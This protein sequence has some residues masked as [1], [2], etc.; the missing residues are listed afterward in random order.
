[1]LYK[2]ILFLAVTLFSLI[3]NGQE[4]DITVVTEEAFPL[5]FSVE[6]EIVGPTTDLVQA[7]LQ[8]ADLSYD[9]AAMPWA[10]AYEQAKYKPNTLIYS[11]ARSEERESIFHWIG[12]VARFEYFFYT[13]KEFADKHTITKDTIKHFRMGVVRNSVTFQHLTKHQFDHIYPVSHPDQNYDKLLNGRIDMFPASRE[14]FE[15][16]CANTRSDC[17]RFIPVLPLQLPVMTLYFAMSKSTPNSVIDKVKQAYSVVADQESTTLTS[18]T[19][20]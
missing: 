15:I 7:V 19:T 13:T 11:M 14:T 9:I 3:V 10:R 20:N 2:G 1:M 17:A 18:T 4:P 6:G 12:E 5:Q 16:S 8:E